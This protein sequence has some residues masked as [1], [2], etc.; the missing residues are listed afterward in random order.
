MNEQELS[1]FL[2]QD[3]VFV[4]S[5]LDGKH[6]VFKIWFTL[7]DGIVR[8]MKFLRQKGHWVFQSDLSMS[9]GQ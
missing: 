2:P 7:A 4:K 1:N 6:G 3:A 5:R 8:S 9:V